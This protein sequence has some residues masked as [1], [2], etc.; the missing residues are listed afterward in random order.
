MAKIINGIQFNNLS[1][2]G[3]GS[4]FDNVRNPY[5]TNE[6]DLQDYINAGEEYKNVQSVLIDWNG[7]QVDNDTIINTTGEILRGA[8]R[9]S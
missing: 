6:S 2:I 8:L 5:I 7:A 3:E 4:S 1:R 9:G